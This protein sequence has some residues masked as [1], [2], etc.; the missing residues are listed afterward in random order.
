MTDCDHHGT[1]LGQGEGRNGSQSNWTLTHTQAPL[2]QFQE[3]PVPS[4]EDRR[5]ERT[6]MSLLATRAE[7][8]WGN[9]TSQV[10]LR[11]LGREGLFLLLACFRLPSSESRAHSY[12]LV[13]SDRLSC[14]LQSVRRNG[15]MDGWQHGSSLIAA[16]CPSS[17][18]TTCAFLLG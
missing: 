13:Q 10:D 3:R 6:S 5:W 4:R 8:C 18:Q 17:P 15:W 9:K 1:Q 11:K 7:L 16:S 14:V 12:P 2:T